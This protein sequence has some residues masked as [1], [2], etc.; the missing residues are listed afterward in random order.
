MID[1]A[2]ARKEGR[3]WHAFYQGCKAR[4]SGHSVNPFK[5]GSESH[6]CWEAGWKYAEGER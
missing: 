2:K 6:A 1:L 4:R 3:R 5:A